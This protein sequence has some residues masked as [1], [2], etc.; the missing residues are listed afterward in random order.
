MSDLKPD[1][2]R[3]CSSV[4]KG[5]IADTSLIKRLTDEFSFSKIFHLA[6]VLSTSGEKTPLLAHHVNV[7]GTLGILELARQHTLRLNKQVMVVFPSTIAAYGIQSL[8]IKRQAGKVDEESFLEP[9]TMYGNNKLYCERLG[10]YYADT[11][12]LLANNNDP[13]IDFRCIRLCGVISAENH[14]KWWDK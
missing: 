8:D 2:S 11:Y 3:H 6:G 14:P 9:I 10:T 7:D 5:S 12:Q 4:I 13:R 1:T